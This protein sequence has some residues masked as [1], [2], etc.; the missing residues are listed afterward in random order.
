MRGRIGGDPWPLGPMPTKNMRIPE[1]IHKSVVFVG[2]RYWRGASHEYEPKATG[3]IVSLLEQNV[4]YTYLV[5]VRHWIVKGMAELPGFDDAQEC[6][7]NRQGLDATTVRH[8]GQWYFH[9]TEENSVDVA[10]CPFECAGLD[11]TPIRVSDFLNDKKI[12]DYYIGPGDEV[13]ITG[14]FTK[15]V[16]KGKNISIVRRGSV[17]M[18]PSDKVPSVNMGDGTASDIDGYLIEVRSVGGLSGSSVFVRAPIGIDCNVFAKSGLNRIAKAHFQG[19]YHFL[20]LCQGH[21]EIPPSGINKI[22]IPSAGE[23]EDKTSI[24]LGIAIVVPAQKILEVI[25]H[26]DLIEQRRADRAKRDALAGQY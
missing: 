6:R 14:L 11:I 12:D 3:F 20:G 17:A 1:E 13:A 7:V 22:P 2:C 8:N 5:T 21:W 23:G 9:P 25:N 26:P 10:V 18:L 24:N 15:L 16:G 19:D 4:S